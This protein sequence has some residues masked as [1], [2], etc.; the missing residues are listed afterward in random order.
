MNKKDENNDFRGLIRVCNKKEELE[1]RGCE[2][3]ELEL[4]M[5]EELEKEFPDAEIEFNPIS[6]TEFEVIIK[7][8]KVDIK[9]YNY[10]K[11]NEIEKQYWLSTQAFYDFLKDL[12]GIG[13]VI[14]DNNFDKQGDIIK[15]LEFFMEETKNERE[16]YL[17]NKFPDEAFPKETVEIKAYIYECIDIKDNDGFVIEIKKRKIASLFFNIHTSLYKEEDHVNNIKFE[18]IFSELWEHQTFGAGDLLDPV[19]YF[20]KGIEI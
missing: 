6:P 3:Y 14:E 19:C 12:S 17:K 1:I 5:R 11:K 10:I 20:Y 16:K 2:E 13:C 15:L 8:T 7:E 9:V 18:P 4:T